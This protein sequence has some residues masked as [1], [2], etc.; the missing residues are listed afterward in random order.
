MVRTLI[1]FLWMLWIPLG[2]TAAD[3]RISAFI[4]DKPVNAKGMLT[5]MV[6]ILT[7]VN[8]NVD[9]NKF[10]IQ[11]KPIAVE[12]LGF[13]KPTPEIL[14]N[15]PPDTIF[16][17]YRF[18]LPA[19][20][21]KGL[22]LL[23]AIQ[24][25]VDGK[26]YAST[27]TTYSVTQAPLGP[28]LRLELE[29]NIPHPF[30]AG[31][32][33]KIIYRIYF[34]DNIDLTKEDLPL[35]DAK[36]FSK[37]GSLEAKDYVKGEFNVSEITQEIQATDPGTFTFPESVIEGKA[38]D[39]SIDGQKAY[40]EPLLRSVAGE[41]TIVVQPF[42]EQ[43]KPASF[44]GASG[45]FTMA[46]R[47]QTPAK[48]NVGDPIILQ[49]TITGKGVLESVTLPKIACQP[50]FSGFFS[51]NDIP[52]STKIS[53][54]SKTFLVEIRPLTTLVKAVPLIEFAYFD[55]EKNRYVI[56]T[57]KEI[58]IEVLLPRME[59]PESLAAPKIAL[60]PTQTELPPALNLG[61]PLPL[62][63]REL[64][65]ANHL[66]AQ[67]MQATTIAA[68][69]DLLNQAFKLYM[70]HSDDSAALYY[71]VGNTL[72]QLNDY[73]AAV[74]FYRKALLRQP[75]NESIKKNLER[76][77]AAL[78]VNIVPKKMWDLHEFLPFSSNIQGVI[79]KPAIVYRGASE[80][81]P[82]ASDSPLLAGETVDIMEISEGG[83]WVKI[84]TSA[85]II[86]FI[87]LTAIRVID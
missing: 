72:F 49:V 47:M 5:G 40:K 34:N 20:D 38:Y 55:P 41:V 74:L 28:T 85:G 29:V 9:E 18:F 60:Q 80:Q 23:P 26:A 25:V 54:N 70:T 2:L 14:G 59:Q 82:Q 30:Y 84:A 21:Q 37:V 3:V 56:L 22:Q 4:E 78:G 6:K 11:G 31:Q 52:I 8:A 10:T 7:S 16:F 75:D 66:Y 51:I 39:I 45:Q 57:S 76:T 32:R 1:V 79:I 35:L 42:A 87:P 73:P 24:V 17:N 62:T 58:P 44:T 13:E 81:F 19:G 83:N 27:P 77:I 46:V 48:V 65:E 33:G 69:Q 43:T 68:R 15:L 67:A 71:N 12:F 50:G 86:G 63:R 53:D 36:G 64:T 61:E